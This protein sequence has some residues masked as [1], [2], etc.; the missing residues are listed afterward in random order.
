MTVTKEL[1]AT[2]VVGV[3]IGLIVNIVTL[4]IVQKMKLKT[5]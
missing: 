4:M 5:V 1:L 2:I 3:F